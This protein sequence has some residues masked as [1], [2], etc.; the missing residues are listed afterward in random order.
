MGDQLEC[1][2]EGKLLEQV[3]Q[4][5]TVQKLRRAAP[6]SSSISAGDPRVEEELKR[7]AV[8]R[9][10]AERQEIEALSSEAKAMQ[11]TSQKSPIVMIFLLLVIYY[12]YFTYST[13]KRTWTEAK[14]MQHTSQMSRIP[15]LYAVSS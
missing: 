11:H 4:M 6:L 2:N 9:L 12:Q 3:Q 15:G 10:R 13:Y 8:R 14:A 7:S 1:D 5:A